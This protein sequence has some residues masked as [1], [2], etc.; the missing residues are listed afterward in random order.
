MKLSSGAARA[1]PWNR[2]LVVW[3]A[4]CSI[5]LCAAVETFPPQVRCGAL[6]FCALR[7]VPRATY[8]ERAPF[9][10]PRPLPCIR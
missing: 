10:R 3:H 7:L 8:A 6:L 1:A 9:W 2:A 4:T 5:S